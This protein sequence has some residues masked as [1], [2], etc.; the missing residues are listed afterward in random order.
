MQAMRLKNDKRLRD[1]LFTP[2]SYRHLA[3]GH[4]GLWEAIIATGCLVPSPT[5]FAEHLPWHP[6][7]D[8]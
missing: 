7:G 3:K 5:S 2:E 8:T 1:K 4:L 6:D